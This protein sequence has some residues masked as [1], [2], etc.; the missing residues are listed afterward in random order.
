MNGTSGKA[1]LRQNNGRTEVFLQ[2]ASGE[3]VILKTFA[4]QEVSAPEYGYWTPVVQNDVK[5]TSPV[6]YSFTD[7]WGFRFVEALSLI[8]ISSGLHHC[9]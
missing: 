2:L 9:S 3:S 4:N 1:R 8:H 5:K 7:K 6:T